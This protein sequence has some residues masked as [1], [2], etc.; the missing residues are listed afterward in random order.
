[1]ALVRVC[2]MHDLSEWWVEVEATRTFGIDGRTYELDLCGEHDAALTEVL[3]PFV[4]QA[5]K[6][7]RR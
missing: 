7:P 2:D 5:R 4:R 3:T 6:L 1:M